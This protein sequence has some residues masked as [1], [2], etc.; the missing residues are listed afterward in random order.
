[1]RG[2]LALM[3]KTLAMYEGIGL[4]LDPQFE[5][6]A[7]AR[8]PM[9]AAMRRLLLPNPDVY[10][11]ALNVQAFLDLSGTFPQRAQRLLGQLERGEL[12]ITVRIG[13]LD[14][15]M[16][17]AS[18]LVNRM[19]LGILVAATILSLGR[20]L[21]TLESHGSTALLILF[22]LAVLGSLVLTVW[23][24]VSMLRARRIH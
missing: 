12:G 7:E 6:V 15:I 8:A 24:L 10:T 4:S 19:V 21:D 1:M 2:D 16:R 13:G 17:H 3:A 20:L 11:T 23:L 9:Q 22:I 5:L 14:P 18:R